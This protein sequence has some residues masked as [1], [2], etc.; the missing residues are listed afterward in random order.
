MNDLT[1]ARAPQARRASL[2]KVPSSRL[3][4]DAAAEEV[5]RLADKLALDLEALKAAI[6]YIN[7]STIEEPRHNRKR[8]KRVLIGVWDDIAGIA[9]ALSEPPPEF[10]ADRGHPKALARHRRADEGVEDLKPA[11]VPAWLKAAAS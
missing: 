9:R 1:V 6:D 11:A 10:R 4:D 5:H 3:P 7:A 2:H 8:A